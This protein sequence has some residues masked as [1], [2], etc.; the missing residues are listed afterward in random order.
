VQGKKHLAR[1]AKTLSKGVTADWMAAC[2]LDSVKCDSMMA[3]QQ[4]IE[5]TDIEAG[6]YSLEDINPVIQEKAGIDVHA[7]NK[8]NGRQLP[9]KRKSRCLH[10]H[11]QQM[12]NSYKDCNSI[13]DALTFLQQKCIHRLALRI[14]RNYYHLLR[15]HA[16]GIFYC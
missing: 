16:V 11:H 1:S 10:V 2:M 4:T 13:I 6:N 8:T 14:S 3:L 5:M 12:K 9:L 7:H 15:L